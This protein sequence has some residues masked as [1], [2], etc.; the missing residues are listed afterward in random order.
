MV[1]ATSRKS[2]QACGNSH[3]HGGPQVAYGEPMKCK[4]AAKGYGVWLFQPIAEAIIYGQDFVKS[5]L[6][7]TNNDF[8]DLMMGRSHLR[9]TPKPTCG[10]IIRC[11]RK[12]RRIM[13][14]W[15]VTHTDCFRAAVTQRSI[16][17][18]ISFYGTSDIGPTSLWKTIALRH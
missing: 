10:P 5:I 15:S 6:M 13:T 1:H 4:P 17:N 8:D 2:R 18:W 9:N 14:N 16:S 3:V 12:L 7:T 11:R